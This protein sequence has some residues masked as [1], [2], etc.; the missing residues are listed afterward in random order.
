MNQLIHNLP[1]A[2]YLALPAFSSSQ[3]KLVLDCPRR[4]KHAMDNP[5]DPKKECFLLGHALHGRT[6]EN[7]QTYVIRPS[8][9]PAKVK[10]EIVEKDWHGGAD[11]CKD[12]LKQHDAQDVLS[13]EQHESVLAWDAAIKA[14]DRSMELLDVEG[15]AEV[16][17]IATDPDTGLQMRIRI[18]WL[19]TDGTALLDVKTTMD[20]SPEGFERTIRDLHYDLSAYSYLRVYNLIADELGLPRKQDFVFIAVEKEPPYI[21]IVYHIDGLFLQTGRRKYELA[22][23]RLC[24][25]LE[26]GNWDAYGND[27]VHHL[28][29][30]D[31]YCKKWGL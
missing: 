23:R 29:P 18:D 27:K 17:G 6:L 20:A 4:L 24:Q 11:W 7:R 28:T 26:S 2:D 15:H 5:E 13:P 1:F 10:G 25:A 30:P 9:Y 14:H 22:T 16:T 19:P 12:W 21:P 8:K 31:W 3:L